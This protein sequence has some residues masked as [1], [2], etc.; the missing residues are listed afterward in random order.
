MATVSE[1]GPV[2]TSFVRR[3]V[4]AALLEVDRY[5]EV[6]ADAGATGQAACVVVLAAVAAGVGGIANHG[7][8]GVLWHTLAQ[9][10]GW[11]LWAVVTWWIGT[12]L[13]PGPH[14]RADRGELLRTIGFASAPGVLRI[15]AVVPALAAPL[16]ALCALWM[17]A[18]MVVAVRQAL[19][20][21]G[22]ARAVAVCALPFP[23]YIAIQMLSLL[24]LGP[25]PV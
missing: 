16:F 13:L 23:L 15:F 8:A 1:N 7:A 24:L 22:T 12:R 11:Y 6:E 20:Y 18:A 21:E 17:C 9:L 10:A 5:E 4:G 2:R 3:V 19:D 14:T 25:W